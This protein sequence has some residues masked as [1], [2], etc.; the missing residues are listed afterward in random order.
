MKKLL[1]LIEILLFVGSVLLAVPARPGFR[2]FDQPDG[3]KFIAQ[4]KGDEHFH[5]AETEDRY[6]IIR[7]SEGWW[8]Y[9]NK[10][11]GLLVPSLFIVGKDNPPFPK[12]LRPDVDKIAAL[13]VNQF[14]Q[15][16]W[17]K[18]YNI[19]DEATT[20]E[21]NNDKKF[22]VVIGCFDDSS[23]LGTVRPT[24]RWDTA[25]WT[26]RSGFTSGSTGGTAHD[27]LYW[28]S[29]FFSYSPGSFRTFFKEISFGRWLIDS[30]CHVQGPVSSGK[31]Y[32]QYGDG[33]EL[34][35]MKD[36]I[37]KSSGRMAYHTTHRADQNAYSD[38]D[39]DGDG[40]VD[41][42]I[43]VRAG[44]EQ[45]ATGSTKDMWAT[46]Y[47]TTVSTTTG[48][49][50]RNPT[51]A[52]E[53]LDS[54]SKNWTATQ[55]QDTQ[56]IR[57]Y[58]MGI[59]VHSHESFHAF[60][61]P[62]LYD[63]GSEGE[64]CGTWSLMDAG[65]WIGDGIQ[66]GSR[67]PHPGAMLQYSFRGYPEEGDSTAGFMPDD[68]DQLITTNGRYFVVG[69]AAESTKLGPRFIQIQNSTFQSAD[70]Y[71]FV[72][73][74]TNKGF[75]ESC[76]PEHGLIIVHY[77]PSEKGSYYNE[78]PTYYTYWVEQR[79]FDPVTHSTYSSD[80]IFRDE[81]Q[82]PYFAGDDYE[83][84]NTTY[85][86]ANQNGST[87]A[88]GPYIISISAPGD[89]MWFTVDNCT[90]PSN[91]SFA[92]K[93]HTVYDT[94]TNYSNNNGVV[95]PDEI[96]DL[97]IAV[98]NVGGNA[99][100]VAAKLRNKQGFVTVLDST[101]DY[102][103]INS[104]T[105]VSNTSDIFRIKVKPSCPTDTTIFFTLDF[106]SS[107][108]SNEVEFGI[109]I[110]STS[111]LYT[112]LL[113]NVSG[114]LTD[115]AGLDLVYSDAVG[116][117]MVISAG[118]GL[119]NA[120][121]TG[122][123][124]MIYFDLSTWGS[125]VKDSFTYAGANYLMDMDHDALGRIW[126]SSG[127]SAHIYDFSSGSPSYVGRVRWPNSDYAG[128]VMKRI[129]G[130]TF[131]NNDSLYAY[132]QTYGTLEESL[133][134]VRKVI[135]GAGTIWKRAPLLDGAGYGG[136]WNNGRGIE[137]DG[138]ALWSVNIYENLIYRKYPITDLGVSGDSIPDSLKFRTIN[139][140][141][142]PS[143]QGSYPAYDLAIQAV[144]ADGTTPAI[145]YAYGNKYY[146]WTMNLDNSEVTKIDITSLVLPEQVDLVIDSCNFNDATNEVTLKWKP[147]PLKDF[148][149]KY[150]VYR[151]TDAN[152][153]ATSKDSVLTT[154]DDSAKFVIPDVKGLHYF[155]VRA[156]N[157]QGYSYNTS[158]EVYVINNIIALNTVS[159]VAT[160]NGSEIYLQWQKEG[161]NNGSEWEISRSRDNGYFKVIGSVDFKSSKFVD[162][163]LSQ[164]G[165][166]TYKLDLV[167]LGGEKV[168]YGQTSI[169]YFNP[170]VFKLYKP[171]TNPVKGSLNI[172]FAIDKE[173]FVTLKI[174]SITGQV[175][176]TLQ[177]RVMS[178][179]RYSVRVDKERLSSGIYYILLTQGSK[180]D[181]I[182]ITVVK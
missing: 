121:G 160:Q 51:N 58:T 84:T 142:C 94:L 166:Y 157:Y 144:S 55:L 99:T 163:T 39:G 173:D 147:N 87:T 103:T 10:V 88:F 50:V 65:A 67:P 120:Y 20:K 143:V 133:Y 159:L 43:V 34:D 149:T 137:W 150:I 92:Y 24:T 171:E 13:P 7:N 76:L 28:D 179:G 130:L 158:D 12:N 52:G 111:L 168:T 177:N 117:W 56:F 109:K 125:V 127:D 3:T 172:N 16:N 77:D 115:A 90:V 70:E 97:V 110:N 82:A 167:K 33:K 122:S 135:N 116:D 6:A 124:K 23:F 81:G 181:K 136:R 96:V 165:A 105:T 38:Y 44:G 75:F 132:W 151:S 141:S 162:K 174:Y 66:A 71:F 140:I 114:S 182:K 74:R 104:L 46:K 37:A 101:A 146:M 83:F 153:F 11:D 60:G 161:I 47:T 152:F 139:T 31:T 131:D 106:T 95:D 49:T 45:S 93:S 178:P 73:N 19:N 164:N 5:F 41:H 129:R 113:R 57:S 145:P 48:A 123:K 154:T 26:L 62:D 118:T 155:K 148:V 29:V 1:I 134:A 30:A 98:K 17:S 85:A 107:N 100:S 61:A 40:Y 79:G 4:L 63:Y 42:W 170:F 176:A 2:V 22:L 9:A 108:G 69:L 119:G 59:G 15:I 27:S 175:V 156:V 89:T 128:T 35:Y 72:E 86:A 18:L 54:L 36:I 21:V 138:S 180:K 25:A 169:K 14:R 32:G 8:T 102:G 91:A 78:G 80:T 53:L 64:P 112:T 126:Y 68:W